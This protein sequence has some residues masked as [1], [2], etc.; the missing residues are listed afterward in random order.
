MTTALPTF[1]AS[2]A[3]HW[4]ETSALPEMS[5]LKSV[6]MVWSARLSPLTFSMSAMPLYRLKIC[7]LSP[8]T[9][10]YILSIRYMV[11]KKFQ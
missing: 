5:A 6:L 10:T 11:K 2:S 1:L 3:F 8:Y 9:L 4:K 7:D